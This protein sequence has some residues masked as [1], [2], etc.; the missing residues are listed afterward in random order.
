MS[1][2]MPEGIVITTNEPAP[3][4][5]GKN[6]NMLDQLVSAFGDMDDTHINAVVQAILPGILRFDLIAPRVWGDAQNLSIPDNVNIQNAFFDT[7][8]GKITVEAGAEIGHYCK[9]IA[10]GSG[11]GKK[12]IHLKKGAV[13][14][15]GALILGPCV[16]GEGAC[17][18]AGSVVLAD[19]IPAG[20]SWAGNPAKKQK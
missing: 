9:F 15:S 11:D 6:E 12:D 8:E 4:K 17:V 2:D 20:E 19:K 14:E 10:S 7:T 18:K 3:K 5:N 13:V 16:V 1:D